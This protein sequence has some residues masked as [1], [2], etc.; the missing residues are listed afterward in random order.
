MPLTTLTTDN[1]YTEISDLARDQG[2]RSKADWLELVDDVV[3]D[4]VELGEIDIED[5][6]DGMKEELRVKWNI[7]RKESAEETGA[8][9][10]GEIEE[11]EGSIVKD[12]KDDDYDYGDGRE[13]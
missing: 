2:V 8:E 13:E 5:D 11:E 3:D 12:E 10:E 7:Y 9:P 1:L 6:V 4:H